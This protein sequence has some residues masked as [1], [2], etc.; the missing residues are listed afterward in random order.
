ML[1]MADGIIV[2]NVDTAAA[3]VVVVVVSLAFLQRGCIV[4][5]AER[6]ISYDRSVSPSVCPSVRHVP[7]FCPQK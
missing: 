2:F 7:M 5:N 6:C 3:A 4:R 1:M